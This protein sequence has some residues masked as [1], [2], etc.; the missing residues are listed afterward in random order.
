MPVSM[1]KAAG[2]EL[3]GEAREPETAPEAPASMNRPVAVIV[4][5]RWM[6]AFMP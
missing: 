5:A 4:S 1:K 6:A 3:T 2:L